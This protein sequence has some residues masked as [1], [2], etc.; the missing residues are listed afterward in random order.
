M[1]A[2]SLRLVTLVS[3]VASSLTRHPGFLSVA[4]ASCLIHFTRHATLAERCNATSPRIVLAPVLRG[5]QIETAPLNFVWPTAHE[6]R[7]PW[8][9][10][11]TQRLVHLCPS[12]L[13]CKLAFDNE[14]EGSSCTLRS[15]SS[16]NI[17]S[18]TASIRHA[19]RPPS[20]VSL[21]L[22]A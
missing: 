18:T 5:H 21:A 20:S 10:R 8:P 22:T 17:L 11:R 19:L 1:Y 7:S 12:V 2:S 9:R 3:I 14:K 6:A 13:P 16:R 4:T 15:L